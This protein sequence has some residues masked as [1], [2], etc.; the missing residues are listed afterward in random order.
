MITIGCCSNSNG[1]QFYNPITGTFVS[2]I[3]YKFQMNVTSG[4]YF[5]PKYQPG[6]FI[7]RLDES[8]SIFAPKF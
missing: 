3:I 5:G 2:L 8:T 4:A 6:T 1:I 7:Y